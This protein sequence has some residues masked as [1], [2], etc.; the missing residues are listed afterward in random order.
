[1]TCVLWLGGVR[2]SLP[3]WHDHARCCGMLAAEDYISRECQPAVDEQFSQM[4]ILF[5]AA[6]AVRV[7][8][9]EQA[10]LPN[11]KS[12]KNEDF[13]GFCSCV[14]TGQNQERTHE[15]KGRVFLH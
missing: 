12:T 14:L 11:L 6:N 5:E 13:A 2:P 1:M 9:L 10:L 8:K 4:K 15:Q 7:C 3:A